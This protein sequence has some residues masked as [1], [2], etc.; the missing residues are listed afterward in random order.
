MAGRRGER[1]AILPHAD[2]DPTQ[3]RRRRRPLRVSAGTVP[4]LTE[5]EGGSAQRVAGGGAKA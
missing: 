1:G 4:G 3:H 2:R 5:P